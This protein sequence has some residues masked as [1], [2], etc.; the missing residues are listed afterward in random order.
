MTVDFARYLNVRSA[1]MPVT[2]PDGGRVAFLSDITGNAQVWSVTTHPGSTPR[3]PEQL[4]FFADKVW[5]IH[6]TP[7]AEH[8]IAVGDVG[9]NE[10][11]QLYLV[12]GFGADSH[13]VIRLTA[14]D[15]AVHRFG[16]FSRD[17]R[18]IVYTSNAR[19]PADFD[20]YWLDLA[21]GEQ[22]RLAE[23]TGNRTIVAWSPDATQLLLL[24]AVATEEIEL[25]LLELQSGVR[26]PIDDG[27][28][29]RTLSC[30][31]VDAGRHLSPVGPHMR[32]W[33]RLPARLG[34]R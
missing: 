3:W 28:A 16:A 8:L 18:Q 9:G 24:D 6:G 22:R 15:E 19:N 21:T 27:R 10:R 31:I 1:T 30:N 17:G 32:S 33:G 12:T 5:E 7:C 23:T 2:A 14:D 26:T 29:G 25:H 20:P 34:E 4:T 13:D 11:Q